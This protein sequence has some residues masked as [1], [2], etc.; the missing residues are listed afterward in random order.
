MAGPI[1]TAVT[2]AT[3]NGRFGGHNDW[4]R[5]LTGPYHIPFRTEQYYEGRPVTDTKEWALMRLRML[6]R[7]RGMITMERM[8]GIE[9]AI[10]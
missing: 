3:R 10:L 6:A 8:A 1:V 5:Y 2:L 9:G 4:H 7:R